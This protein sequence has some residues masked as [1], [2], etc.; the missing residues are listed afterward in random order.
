MN[1]A[2]YQN[3]PTESVYESKTNPRRPHAVS[4]C[5]LR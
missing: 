1:D 5:R 2:T 3:V 4:A